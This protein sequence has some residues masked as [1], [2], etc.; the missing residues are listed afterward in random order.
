MSLKPVAS[1]DAPLS[2][3]TDVALVDENTACVINS[4]E[5]LVQCRNRAGSRVGVFGGEGEG[6]GEFRRPAY[7]ERG[8]AGT[9]GVFDLALRRMTVFQASGTRLSET[10]LPPV[11]F[12]VGPF[13]TSVTG[14]YFTVPE[15]TPVPIEVELTSGEI[16]WEW[17]GVHDLVETECGMLGPGLRGPDGGYVFRACENELV[18]VPAREAD[19]ATVVSA[20]TYVPEL[21][22]ER[23]VDA[24]REDLAA[25]AGGMS[26]PRSAMTPY[27]DSFREEPKM[28]FLV[29]RSLAYDGVGRLWVATTRDRDA[30][31]YLDVYVGVDYAGTVRIR[32][33]LVGYDL[34]G[35]TMAAL[36]ERT[37][38]PNGVGNRAIDW[39]QIDGVNSPPPTPLS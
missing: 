35:S 19:R 26:M 20:P 18:F 15:G 36:V 4:H 14:H 17:R 12:P 31:S 25:M 37:P 39:Y 10:T 33:R 1:V 2:R 32:D 6:P 30:S 27:L 21:P 9:L 13:G 3:N 22:N 11:F 24:Y 16:L 8:P 7:V 28:W 5:F 29:P 34:L 23:D 38:G